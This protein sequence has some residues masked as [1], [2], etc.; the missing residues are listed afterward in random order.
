MSD[1]AAKVSNVVKLLSASAAGICGTLVCYPLDVLRLNM[2]VSGEMGKKRKSVTTL[3]FAREIVKRDGFLGLYQGL[4]ASVG[5]QGLYTG[6]RLGLY[7]I[8]TDKYSENNTIGYLEKILIGCV[9]GA[10]GAIVGLPPDVILTRMA[11]DNRLPVN[12]RRNYKHVFDG[13][14][15]IYVDEGIL[16][17]YRGAVPTICRAVVVNVS[18]VELLVVITAFV[19]YLRP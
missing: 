8:L 15:R 5:R 13:F 4:S 16:T 11:V 9:S 1:G 18:Q 6:T 2:Q 10:I 7:Q 12:E 3:E 19:N 17:L 14:R